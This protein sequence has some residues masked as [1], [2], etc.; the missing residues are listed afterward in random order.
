MHCDRAIDALLRLALPI[1]A[2]GVCSLALLGCQAWQPARYTPPEFGFGPPLVSP[3]SNPLLVTSMDRDFVWEQVVDV[4][5]DYFRIEH[6]ERVRLV[7]DL[8]TEGVLQ[9]Y[10][11]T[12]STIFEPWNQDSVT[13]YERWQAT[14]Q[15][16]RRRAIVRVI[17]AEGGFLVDVQVYKE[18]EDVPRPE[19]GAVSLANAET[20]RNDDALV[21]LTNPLGGQEP[22]VGWLALGRDTALEQVILAGIQARAGGMMTSPAHF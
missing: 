5:D 17:P 18:L 1:C 22:T 10:P 13:P 14:L 7:G 3:E 15:S 6:E 4:V 9:T 11:R 2:L 21:R 8:L 19:S 20:L 12:A 16:M